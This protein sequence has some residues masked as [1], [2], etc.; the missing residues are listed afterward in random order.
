MSLC[1]VSSCSFWQ[2]SLSLDLSHNAQSLISTWTGSAKCS[3]AAVHHW[4]MIS[5][6][7]WGKEH[8]SWDPNAN[9]KA[10]LQHISDLFDTKDKLK[11]YRLERQNQE[12]TKNPKRVGQKSKTQKSTK[13]RRRG[14]KHIHRTEKTKKTSTEH[15][16]TQEPNAYARLSETQRGRQDY[17]YLDLDRLFF[18]WDN[19][20]RSGWKK[21]GNRRN[22]KI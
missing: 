4:N 3:T 1:P 6:T 10:N 12:W 22:T 21:E 9:L 15:K 14:D 8:R 16:T 2:I 20:H 13:S 5:V 17:I 18:T 19:Y 7:F 11:T